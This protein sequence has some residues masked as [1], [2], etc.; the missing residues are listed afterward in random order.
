MKFAS[1]FSFRIPIYLRGMLM[2]AA[3]LIPG[4]SGG[5]VALITGIYEEFIFA[6]SALF[7]PDNLRLVLRGRWRPFWQAVNGNFLMSLFAGI[8]T[9][10]LLFSSLIR[11]LFIH[12]PVQVWSFF[13]GLIAASSLMVL[14]MAGSHT[15]RWFFVVAGA[16]IGLLIAWLHPAQIGGNVSLFMSFFAG[17]AASMAMILPGISGSYILILLGM[18]ARVLEWVHRFDVLHLAVFV[19]GVGAGITGFSR[20]LRWLLARYEKPTLSLLGG[21]LLGSLAMIWPWKSGGVPVWP[22][23]YDGNPHLWAAIGLALTGIVLIL[24]LERAAKK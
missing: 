5:T 13:F 15:G 9:S 23:S 24:G 7:E 1:G 12:Y 10:V 11:W 16:V 19:L 2:G 4:V 3:D 20:L 17:M 21:F 22:A 8:L 18:Y 14:R 6:L